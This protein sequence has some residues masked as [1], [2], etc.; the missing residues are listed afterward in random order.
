MITNYN[1]EEELN[2]IRKYE[3]IVSYLYFAPDY[4]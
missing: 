3:A 1:V 2:I 4:S